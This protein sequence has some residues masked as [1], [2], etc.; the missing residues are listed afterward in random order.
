MRAGLLAL[1]AAA[2]GLALGALLQS[3]TTAP[4][5]PAPGVVDIGFAQHMSRHHDQAVMLVS[6]FLQ[7]HD[8]PLAG[9]SHRI[10]EGQLVEL[11]QMRGWLAL[12][13]EPLTPDSLAMSWMLAGSEPPDD[14]LR[15]YLLACEASS[16]GMPGLATTDEIQT[17]TQAEG[18]T[19]DRIFLELMQRHHEGGLPMLNFAAREAK[20]PAV[21]QLAE[22][23]LVEQLRE[24]ARM[25]GGMPAAT[26]GEPGSAQRP[27]P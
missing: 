20:L 21:R 17:L 5:A 4:A 23:M 25:R 14:E 19:R 22:R 8:T 1:T 26:A 6:L 13:D 10:L 2:I 12:W 7:K 11:G 16:S 3:R 15:A 24:I 18:E 27:A 9:F